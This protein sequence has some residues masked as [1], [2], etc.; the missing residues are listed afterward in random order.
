L[1]SSYLWFMHCLV[2][3]KNV[4]SLWIFTKL[5]FFLGSVSCIFPDSVSVFLIFHNYFSFNFIQVKSIQTHF[6][7]RWSIVSQ[8]RQLKNMTKFK[9]KRK[10]LLLILWQNQNSTMVHL[11]HTYMRAARRPSV[12]PNYYLSFEA[13]KL[14][15]CIETPNINGQ[16]VF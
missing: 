5:F 12:T 10:I 2:F 14:K 13:R 16:K 15:F 3:S 8:Q 9:P 1:E 4:S 7:P 11:G 6:Q